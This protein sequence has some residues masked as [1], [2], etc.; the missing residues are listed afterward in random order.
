MKGHDWR[1]VR[2][3]TG[4]MVAD[5]TNGATSTHV[6][7]QKGYIQSRI[8]APSRDSGAITSATRVHVGASQIHLAEWRTTSTSPRVLR[9]HHSQVD[10]NRRAASAPEQKAQRV[11]RFAS[12]PSLACVTSRFAGHNMK[13]SRRLGFSVTSI[14]CHGVNIYLSSWCEYEDF[15]CVKKTRDH[16]SFYRCTRGLGEEGLTNR[17][18]SARCRLPNTPHTRTTCTLA[19]SG[20]TTTM[21]TPGYG[22]AY[23]WFATSCTAQQQGLTIRFTRRVAYEMFWT[24]ALSTRALELTCTCTCTCTCACTCTC[25]SV[26]STPDHPFFFP[27]S[28]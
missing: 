25:E 12:P 20:D 13:K 1:N 5:T 28:G 26:G 17:T 8:G 23:T 19:H 7:H 27:I 10:V 22:N 6:A 14:T 3:A 11:A 2:L 18:P 9:P 15:E 16:V 24:S 4:G 21:V